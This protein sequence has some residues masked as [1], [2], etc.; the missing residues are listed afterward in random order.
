M[1]MT[2]G[3]IALETLKVC[4]DLLNKLE[5]NGEDESAERALYTQLSTA[6]MAAT[7]CKIYENVSTL[8]RMENERSVTCE[9][10]H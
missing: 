5:S 1:I 10:R 2:A 3:E 7:G 9:Q 6:A 4:G 8:D